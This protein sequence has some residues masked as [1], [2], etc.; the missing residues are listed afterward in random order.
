MK[1][2]FHDPF[3]TA[4][5]AAQYFPGSITRITM[6]RDVTSFMEKRTSLILPVLVGLENSGSMLKPVALQ[7]LEN[8]R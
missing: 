2:P 3:M 4:T 1:P 8:W 6:A 5:G 7:Q